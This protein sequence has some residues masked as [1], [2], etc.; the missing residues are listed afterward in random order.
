METNSQLHILEI[1]KFWF[2]FTYLDLDAPQ[3]QSRLSSQ[4]LSSARLISACASRELNKWP[5]PQEE[6]ICSSFQLAFQL[7]SIAY[8][9]KSD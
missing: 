3:E 5:F 1:L 7:L 2:K 4:G 8:F 9:S 6:A